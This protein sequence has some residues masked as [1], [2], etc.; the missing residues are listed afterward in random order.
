M[1]QHILASIQY[2]R[3]LEKTVLKSSWEKTLV[4]TKN[5]Q[6]HT[7]KSFF[8]GK[9]RGEIEILARMRGGGGVEQGV[10]L[11]EQT[12]THADWREG[13]RESK[14]KETSI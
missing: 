5:A 11:L 4:P 7:K 1:Q 12:H 13:G 8:K 10:V 3:H 6:F 2:I 14:R 9:S